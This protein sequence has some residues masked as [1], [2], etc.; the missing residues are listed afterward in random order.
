[1]RLSIDLGATAIV[2]RAGHRLRVDLTSSSFPRFDRN[3]N[4]GGDI[5]SA[6]EA[7]HV[8]AVQRVFHDAL[9]PSAIHLSVLEG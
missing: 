3:P 5:A 2:I 4:H 6:T 7:D 8:V 1:M 9:H